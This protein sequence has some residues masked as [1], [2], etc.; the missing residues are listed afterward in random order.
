MNRDD[1]FEKRL[2]RQP[3]REIPSAWREEILS[4]AERAAASRHSS[5]ATRHSWLSTLNSQL[6]TLLWPCP[7]AWAGLA[8]VWLVI[9][10]VDYATQET[11]KMA[12][13]Q[14]TPPSSQVRQLLKQ[15]EQLLAELVGPI[16]KPEVDRRRPLAPQPRSQY[17]EEFLN[18]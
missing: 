11:P 16:E 3:L 9:L 5:P 8:A 17:R 7:Q 6:S 15:Q 13:R 18:A 2:Q 12:S 10:G 1:Q 14:I 4:A